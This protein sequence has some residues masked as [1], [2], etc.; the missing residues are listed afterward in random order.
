MSNYYIGTDGDT[1]YYNP[2]FLKNLNKK[3]LKVIILNTIIHYN[4][5]NTKP[6]HY[7]GLKWNIACDFKINTIIKQYINQN[8]LESS[9][10]VSKA[11]LYNNEYKHMTIKE[12]Y[13][14][15]P[16]D[17]QELNLNNF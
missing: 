9:L 8:N 10:E 15:L 6:D 5:K 4:I 16:S 11:C 17:H 13:D 12:I 3:N 14:V 7:D 1:L 2:L